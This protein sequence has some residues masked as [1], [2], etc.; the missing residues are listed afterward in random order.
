[1]KYGGLKFGLEWAGKEWMR[2]GMDEIVYIPFGAIHL[3]SLGWYS[4]KK[5]FAP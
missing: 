3:Q 2:Q 5:E 1:M 4:Y